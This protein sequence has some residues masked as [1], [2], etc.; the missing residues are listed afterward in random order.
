MSTESAESVDLEGVVVSSFNVMGDLGENL[1]MGLACFS[2]KVS[3]LGMFVM[4]VE[5]MEGEFEALVLEDEG[6]IGCVEKGAEFDLLSVVLDSEVRELGGVLDTLQDGVGEI[7]EWVCSSCTHLGEDSVV[8]MKDK[9]VGFEQKLKQSEEELNDIKMQ[10]ARFQ[11]SLASFKK[12]E[13]GMQGDLILFISLHIYVWV[14]DFF[15]N[16]NI[17][18]FL[19]CFSSYKKIIYL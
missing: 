1:D 13:N 17:T 2:E 19:F 4:H 15:G 6:H 5:T 3:N 8:A 18:F 10:S 7:R 11:K 16:E 14:K 9:L 12:A